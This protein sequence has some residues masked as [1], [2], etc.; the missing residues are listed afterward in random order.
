MMCSFRHTA[1]SGACHL[2]VPHYLVRSEFHPAYPNALRR[3]I[4]REMTP[5]RRANIRGAPPATTSDIASSP[6]PEQEPRQ[7]F[8]P[9]HLSMPPT[10]LCIQRTILMPE[11]R[12][13]LS[14]LP[15][16][17]PAQT[18]LSWSSDSHE[19]MAQNLVETSGRRHQNNPSF[20]L[21]VVPHYYFG[22]VR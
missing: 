13:R 12:T 7:Q 6:I 21:L 5:T 14:G 11:C 4:H 10:S 8:N 15:P 22:P 9:T 2:R 17:L 3:M 18:K 20:P 19:Q 1:F 16:L